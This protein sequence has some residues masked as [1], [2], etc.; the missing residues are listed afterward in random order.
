MEDKKAHIDKY[1]II[2]SKDPDGGSYEDLASFKRTQTHGHEQKPVFMS[3][4]KKKCYLDDA[5]KIKRHSLGPGHYSIKTIN[6]AYDK[7]TSSPNS[8]RT[9]R[10]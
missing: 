10:H 6:T 8:I 4:M 2:K 5:I 7:I 3:K 1:K 9:K